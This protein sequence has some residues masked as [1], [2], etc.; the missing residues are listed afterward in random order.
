VSLDDAHSG[1]ELLEQVLVLGRRIRV[2]LGGH[3]LTMRQFNALRVLAPEPL[4][5][6]Q[7]AAAVEISGPSAVALVDGLEAAGHVRRRP[8]PDDARASLIELTPKGTRLLRGAQAHLV[9]ML[10]R[11]AVVDTRTTAP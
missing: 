2:E 11:D 9:E 7:L 3:G 10:E 8:D 6:G 4:R 5:L 1:E